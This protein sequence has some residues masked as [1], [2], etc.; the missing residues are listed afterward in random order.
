[1]IRKIKDKMRSL[2][3]GILERFGYTFPYLD[4]LRDDAVRCIQ[5]CPQ[6]GQLLCPHQLFY[7]RPPDYVRDF[8]VELGEI[9]LVH[10][11]KRGISR[12]MEP[13]AEWAFVIDRLM[14]GSGVIQVVIVVTKKT[15]FRIKFARAK[16]PDDVKAQVKSITHAFDIILPEDDELEPETQRLPA[17][18]DTHDVPAD[19]IVPMPLQ[20]DADQLLPTPV[21]QTEPTPTLDDPEPATKHGYSLRPRA[22]RIDIDMLTVEQPIPS[23][24]K[25]LYCDFQDD[26]HLQQFFDC[27]S[28]QITYKQAIKGPNAEQAERSMFDEISQI[29]QMKLFHGRHIEDLS[30]A[31]RELILKATSAYKEKYLPSGIFE[32]SKSRLLVRGDMQRPEFT[33]EK[34]VHQLRASKHFLANNHGGIY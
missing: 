30:P 23:M 24:F 11:P 1:M 20:Q 27:L 8:R 6:R 14:D 17:V 19:A 15:A 3:Y 7:K 28:A 9:I 5:R 31:E 2:Q 4:K 32:K 12:G 26:T 34:A 22:P 33:G 13:K 21:E 29:V 16:V 25:I 10:R 18:S